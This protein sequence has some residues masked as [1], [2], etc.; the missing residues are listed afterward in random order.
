MHIQEHCLTL[1]SV[2]IFWSPVDLVTGKSIVS[3][4]L[5]CDLVS[6]NLW[7]VHVFLTVSRVD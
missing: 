6:Q 3:D 1:M 7:H 2:E 5:M 4:S